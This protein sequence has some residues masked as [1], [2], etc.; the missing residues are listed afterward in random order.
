MEDT[1]EDIIAKYSKHTVK[2]PK[3]VKVRAEKPLPNIDKDVSPDYFESD[4]LDELINKTEEL[5]KK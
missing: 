2:A 3:A 5:I 4:E 1:E